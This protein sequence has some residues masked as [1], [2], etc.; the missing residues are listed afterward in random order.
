MHSGTG[1]TALSVRDG[2]QRNRGRRARRKDDD[3]R[4][5]DGPF[6]CESLQLDEFDAYDGALE[7]D[8]RDQRTEAMD[9]HAEHRR[10]TNLDR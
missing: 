1:L 5:P 4:E 3:E 2:R 7:V 10:P 8:G 6:D 9:S